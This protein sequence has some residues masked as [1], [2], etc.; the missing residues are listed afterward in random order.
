MNDLSDFDTVIHALY[1]VAAVSF[2]AGLHLMTSPASARRGNQVSAGGM[3]LAFVTTVVLLA[4]DHVM[5]A[6]ATLVLIAGLIVGS[7]L[8]GITARRIQMTSMPQLVSLFNAV[9]GGAAALIAAGDAV[10]HVGSKP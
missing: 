2:V 7:L 4:H 10:S 8:G 3:V 1:L 6:T 5:T 9:G